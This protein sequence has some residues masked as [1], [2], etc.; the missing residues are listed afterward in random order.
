M[1]EKFCGKFSLQLYMVIDVGGHRHCL[2]SK[3]QFKAWYELLIDEVACC[4]ERF[5]GS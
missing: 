2:C 5:G 4:D 3:M 1:H